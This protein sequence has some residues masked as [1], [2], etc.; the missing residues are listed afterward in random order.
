M[1]GDAD[2]RLV[3]PA[4][5]TASSLGQQLTL[6]F[7]PAAKASS[8]LSTS[9]NA[10]TLHREDALSDTHAQLDLFTNSVDY[11]VSE[12]ATAVRAYVD[13]CLSI[14][15]RVKMQIVQQLEMISHSGTQY[16]Y[17]I[18][19]SVHVHVN[20]YTIYMYTSTRTI[21]V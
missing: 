9:T 19:V 5:E 7:G 3:F 17:Y 18:H 6:H 2:A 8:D 4:D 10:L 1:P 11:S 15:V 13:A 14:G 20:T 16:M 12:N 21:I